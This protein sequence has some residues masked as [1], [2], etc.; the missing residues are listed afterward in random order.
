MEK[1]VCMLIQ[2]ECKMHNCILE[3]TYNLCQMKG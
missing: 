3:N 2:P 1:N